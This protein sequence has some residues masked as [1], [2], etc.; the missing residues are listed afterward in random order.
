MFAGHIGAALALGRA[1]PRIPPGVMVSAA[2]L[3]DLLD[4]F[5]RSILR[6]L[7]VMVAEQLR[8]SLPPAPD[9]R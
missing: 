9:A 2:L 3:P 1:E 4:P 6:S 5:P 8:M 7:G